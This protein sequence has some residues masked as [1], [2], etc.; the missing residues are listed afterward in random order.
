MSELI[1]PQLNDF[2]YCYMMRIILFTINHLLP[3]HWHDGES[4]RQCTGKPGFNPRSSHTKYSKN[5]T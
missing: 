4:V 2:N 5:G 3:V 1:F